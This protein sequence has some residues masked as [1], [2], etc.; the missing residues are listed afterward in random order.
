MKGFFKKHPELLIIL[1]VVIVVDALIVYMWLGDKA[2]TEKS[3]AEHEKLN[4]AAHAINTSTYKVSAAN[5]KLAEDEVATWEKAF[6]GLIAERQAKYAFTGEKFQQSATAKRVLKE[7][8][9]HLSQ[10][11]LKDKDKTSDKLSF[12][13]YAYENTM[14]SMKAEEIQSVFVAL[15]GVEQIVNTAVTSDIISLDSIERPNALAFEVDAAL[16]TKRYTYVLKITAAADGFKKLVNKIVND[17]KFFFEINSIKINA[18][19][20]V[21]VST[22]D[23]VPKIAR[24]GNSAAATPKRGGGIRDL[25]E[26]F[27]NLVNPAK[28]QEESDE[29]FIYRDSISPFSQAINNVEIS[30]DWVQFTKE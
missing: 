3:Q 8:V 14:L 20:Q 4:Q 1:I 25:E 7:R 11:L 6:D 12:F 24:K 15:K 18:V 16:K 29:P 13:T 19:E 9:D 30:I 23:L 26:G 2:A 5:A 17:E 21:S 28:D 22:S 27:D 10:K